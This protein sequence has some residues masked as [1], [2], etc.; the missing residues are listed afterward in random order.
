ME[1]LTDRLSIMLSELESS[2]LEVVLIPSKRQLN[3]WD[4]LRCCVS[5]N[6]TWYR[7]FCAQF[8]SKRGVRRGKFDTAIRRQNILRV[9]TRLCAGMTSRSKYGPELV[10]VAGRIKL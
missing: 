3:E 2:R 4:M 7:K 1:C 9:L 10:K 8:P 5:Y 6:C